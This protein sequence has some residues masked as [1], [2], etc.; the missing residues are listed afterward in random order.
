MRIV[1]NVSSELKEEKASGELKKVL[2]RAMLKMHELAVKNAP[3]FDGILRNKIFLSPGIIGFDKYSL[4]SPVEYSSDVEFG[5]KPHY[6]S[7]FVLKDWARR[8]LG[9]EDAAFAVAR[10]IA[11]FGTDAQPFMR[12][13]FNQVKNIWLPRYIS[14]K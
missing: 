3:V 5:T 14:Q 6:V 2:F 9:D 1:F 12:P 13:A 11:L 7:P 4:I 10:K 8:K